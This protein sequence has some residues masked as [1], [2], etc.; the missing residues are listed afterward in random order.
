MECKQILCRLILFTLSSYLVKLCEMNSAPPYAASS[1]E[2]RDQLKKHAQELR[3]S[4]ASAPCLRPCYD[5]VNTPFRRSL[6]ESAG[7]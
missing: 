5:A 6:Y 3:R 1:V 4:E 7:T 2:L